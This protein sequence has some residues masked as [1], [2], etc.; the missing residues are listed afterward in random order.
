MEPGLY[1]PEKGMGLRIEDTY[2]INHKN[3]VELM[4]KYPYDLIIPVKS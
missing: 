3:Q 2:C 1:Y 4:A